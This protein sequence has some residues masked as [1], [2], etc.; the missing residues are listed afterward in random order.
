MQTIYIYLTTCLNIKLY[1]LSKKSL[2]SFN[3]YINGIAT[4]FVLNN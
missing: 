3:G 1:Y 2:L 4:K